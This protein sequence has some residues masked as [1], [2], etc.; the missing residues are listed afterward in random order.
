MA[1]DLARATPQEAISLLD[2]GELRIGAMYHASPAVRDFVRREL[3][4]LEGEVLRNER[5]GRPGLE[6]G[7]HRELQ[8]KARRLGFWGINTPEEYGGAGVASFKYNAVLDEELARLPV[9]LGGIGLQSYCN[10]AAYFQAD[11]SVPVKK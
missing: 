2:D 10:A 3:A 11:F 1:A 9:H 4:P 5:E 6:P 8:E 7:R